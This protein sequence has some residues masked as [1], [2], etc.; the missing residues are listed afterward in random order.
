ME[1]SHRPTSGVPPTN[2]PPG[3]SPP[4]E[5]FVFVCFCLCSKLKASR[6]FA[7]PA[8]VQHKCR[9]PWGGML[10]APTMDHTLLSEIFLWW[11]L[12]RAFGFVVVL[13]PGPPCFSF[14]SLLGVPLPSVCVWPEWHECCTFKNICLLLL[15]AQSWPVHSSPYCFFFV[16]LL[17]LFRTAFLFGAPLWNFQSVLLPGFPLSLLKTSPWPMS[18]IVWPEHCGHLAGGKSRWT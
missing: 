12:C 15:W 9:R 6:S 11:S 13:F 7:G 16:F 3:L 8:H 5:S 14:L 10:T 17:L 18:S 4:A 1:L 2:R